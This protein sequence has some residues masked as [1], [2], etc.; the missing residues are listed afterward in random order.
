MFNLYN[1]KSIWYTPSHSLFPSIALFQFVL[2]FPRHNKIV[3]SIWAH[4][5]CAN[6]AVLVSS[7][8]VSSW[9][10]LP[11]CCGTKDRWFPSICSQCCLLSPTGQEAWIRKLKWP[12]LDQFSQKRWKPLYV[13]PESMVTAAF[14]KAYENFAFFWILKAGHMVSNKIFGMESARRL[15]MCV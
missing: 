9:T 10:G 14:H 1:P 15:K 12:D 6:S 5:L 7:T 11:G 13:S 2:N 4:R 3:F 8:G